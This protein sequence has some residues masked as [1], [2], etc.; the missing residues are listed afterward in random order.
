MAAGAGACDVIVIYGLGGRPGVGGVTILTHIVGCDMRGRFARCRR[1]IVAGH[2]RPRDIAVA[3]IRGRPGGRCMTGA[4]F[5]CGLKMCRRLSGCL[6][7]VVATRAR[8]DDIRM[9]NGF[10]RRPCIGCV[11]VFAGIGRGYMGRRFTGRRRAIVAGRTGPRHVGVTEGRRAP[12]IGRMAGAAFCRCLKVRR[13]LSSGLGAIVAA[14]TTADH[15]RMIDGL[16]R[17][18]GGRRVAILTGGVGRNM[19]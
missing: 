16:G 6:G 11:T 1:A 7:A 12:G 2:A 8:A 14:R 18:P 15:I 3:E 13:R 5:R 10:G 9:I 4:A 19:S 17:G